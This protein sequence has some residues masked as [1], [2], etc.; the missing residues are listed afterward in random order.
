MGIPTEVLRAVM[1]TYRKA[2]QNSSTVST[3]GKAFCK[4]EKIVRLLAV[5]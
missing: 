4:Q 3:I 5:N 2:G 1:K